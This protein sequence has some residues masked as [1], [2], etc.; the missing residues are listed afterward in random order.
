M[1]QRKRKQSGFSLIE[2][3]VVV[4]IVL[5]IA[6]IAIPSYLRAK[7]TANESAAAE[8]VKNF[9]T[10]ATQYESSWGVF[11]ATAGAMAGGELSLTAAATCAAG[12]D[13]PTTT[14][15]ALAAATGLS[16]SGYTFTFKQGA[17]AKTGNAG[18]AGVTGFDIVADPVDVS[19]GSRSFCADPSGE[20]YISPGVATPASGASCLTDL[21]ATA[22]PLGQ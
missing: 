13:L 3:L 17:T 8:M 21:G 11:P 6:A 7:S 14:T 5:I 18:C 10:A 19:Q 22:K 9:S 15:T 16:Q 1:I 2:L 20:Y 4:A 12:Q